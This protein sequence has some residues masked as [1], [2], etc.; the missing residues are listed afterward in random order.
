MTAE[1]S[2]APGQLC[3]ELLSQFCLKSDVFSPFL[4]SPCSSHSTE[5]RKRPSTSRQ[6]CSMNQGSAVG[7]KPPELICFKKHNETT[8]PIMGEK[9]MQ[10]NEPC[11]CND[12]CT[13]CPRRHRTGNG[14]LFCCS[15]ASAMVQWFVGAT[16][17]VLLQ[18]TFSI[19]LN[20]RSL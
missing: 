5:C 19:L 20:R 4:Y 14:R 6:G 7:S 3:R 11:S 8:L 10:G 1:L 16:V 13:L 17:A 18:L 2:Q 12:I 9:G 15:A